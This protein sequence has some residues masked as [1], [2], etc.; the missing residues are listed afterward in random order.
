M[1]SIFS[2]CHICYD[3]DSRTGDVVSQ[4]EEVLFVTDN[5][6]LAEEFVAKYSHDRVY[7]SPGSEIHTG[8]LVVRSQSLVETFEDIPTKYITWGEKRRIK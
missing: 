8:L 3:V 1:K 4:E 2:V 6:A 5:M 7:A